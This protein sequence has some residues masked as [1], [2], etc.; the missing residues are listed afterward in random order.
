M[1]SDSFSMTL[2]APAL[3][4][5]ATGWLFLALC[6]L[7]GA[8]LVVILIILARQPAIHTLIPWTG[9]FRTALVIHVDL[10]VLVW[11]LSFAGFLATLSLTERFASLGKIA[12]VAASA[13]MV[14]LA[15]SPFLG[16]DMPFMNNYVPVL[17][18]SAFFL[19]I[20]L[21]TAGFSLLA[22]LTLLD[23][24]PAMNAGEKSLRFG[25]LSA[26]VIFFLALG[27]LAWSWFAL[28]TVG[29]VQHDEHYF[30]LLF[31][32]SGHI[33]QFTHVQLQMLAW[34]LLASWAGLASLLTPRFVFFL[35]LLGFAPALLGPIIHG[36]YTV[37]SL[38]HRMAFTD[39]MIYGGGVASGPL[40]LMLVLS[41]WR[42]KKS[43]TDAQKTVRLSLFFSLALF[44]FGSIIGFMIRGVNVTIPAHY[45]GAI[46][47]VTLAYM[48]LTYHLLPRLGFQAPTAKWSQRQ[49]FLY[50]VGSMIHII[51]LAWSGGH[52]VQRKTAGAE[53][54]LKTMADKIPMWTMGVGGILAVIG[55]IAFL[56]LAFRALRRVNPPTS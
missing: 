11:F 48:G 37:D 38:E 20:G 14:I 51:G 29:M 49:L 13:G 15:F 4:R 28:K 25:L 32:G 2:P 50:S 21:F 19:G 31:W 24:H 35:F 10:S 9:S 27:S 8:G 34:L 42:S 39:L 55:G 41:L 5:L 44:F 18:N 53:Q 1:T 23:R 36:L 26:L 22:L 12:L 52:D 7:V 30:E 33:L 17:N 54:G 40:S 43:A 46:V 56:L 16:E 45:H 6:S 3:R 47:S